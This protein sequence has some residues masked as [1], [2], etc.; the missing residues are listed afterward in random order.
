MN[1]TIIYKIQHK[2][3]KELIYI[4]S[5]IDFK[6][7]QREHKL[8]CKEQINFKRPSHLYKIINLNGGW[9]AFE[10]EIIESFF[11]NNGKKELL[12]KELY[13]IVKFNCIMNKNK[14]IHF[15]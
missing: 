11:C 5:T 1:D 3:N 14:P 7:R 8:K 10:M 2:E 4:G 13:Y 6:R 15:Y 12:T 9:D